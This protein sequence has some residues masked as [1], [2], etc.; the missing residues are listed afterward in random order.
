MINIKKKSGLLCLLTMATS[1]FFTACNKSDSTPGGGITPLTY[2]FA[3]ADS[4]L[5]PQGEQS[6][7]QVY[8]PL[9]PRNGIYTSFPEGL[10]IDQS[11]GKIKIH[12][13]ETGIKYRVYY[14][15]T[16]GLVKDSTLITVS[17]INFLDGVYTINTIDSIVKPLYNAAAGNALPG[18]GSGSLFDEG[19]GC[20]GGGCALDLTNA[21]INLAQTVRNGVFGS[22]PTNGSSKEFTLNF[23]LNDR[24]GKGGNK[25][26]F[27]VFYFKKLS[28]VNQQVWDLLNGRNGTVINNFSNTG[29]TPIQGFTGGNITQNSLTGKGRRPPCVVILS[30]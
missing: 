19:G 24:S 21:K 11:S 2:K 18:S 28:D 10:E 15:S 16:D 26:K 1:I 12:D 22:T 29:N 5:Y 23:R 7:V 30:Q 20:N 27:K 14:R 13:S 25:I 17:G 3:Y 6:E 8:S 9:T 4:V